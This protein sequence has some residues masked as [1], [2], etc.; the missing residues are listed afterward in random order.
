MILFLA[1]GAV[2]YLLKEALKH[3][4]ERGIENIAFLGYPA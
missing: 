3:S 2:G 1:T 4:L